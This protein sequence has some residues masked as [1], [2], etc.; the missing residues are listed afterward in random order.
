MTGEV[1][2]QK[3]KL[4]NLLPLTLTEKPSFKKKKSR[5]YTALTN[6]TTADEVRCCK[7]TPG[8]CYVQHMIIA[9]EGVGVRKDRQH[10]HGDRPTSLTVLSRYIQY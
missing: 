6:W 2:A 7:V 8:S 5:K 10:K 4:S 1:T 3:G 9:E